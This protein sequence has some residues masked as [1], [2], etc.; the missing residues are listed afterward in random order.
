MVMIARNSDR[1]RHGRVV[2]AQRLSGCSKLASESQ[3]S[4]IA[5]QSDRIWLLDNDISKYPHSPLT[6]TR[7]A[8][9]AA[10]EVAPSGHAFGEEIG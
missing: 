1:G 5:R 4:R 10:N 8:V 9:A 6:C 3:R 7:E 2:D